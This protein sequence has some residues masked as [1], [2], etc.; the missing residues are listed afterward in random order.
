MSQ[1]KDLFLCWNYGVTFKTFIWSGFISSISYFETKM[2]SIPLTFFSQNS[3]KII[4]DEIKSDF[5]LDGEDL[6]C[7]LTLYNSSNSITRW[8]YKTCAN[9]VLLRIL[10]KTDFRTLF[11][12]LR[13]KDTKIEHTFAS[14][15]RCDVNENW[16][17]NVSFEIKASDN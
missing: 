9:K 16:V 12:S 11:S 15:I 6:S 2:N 14:Q 7:N 10:L 4:W 3:N 5:Q 1:N 13:W 17:G 8:F